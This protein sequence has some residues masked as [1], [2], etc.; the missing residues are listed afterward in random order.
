MVNRCVGCTRQFAKDFSLR[1]TPAR[2]HGVAFLTAR[3]SAR[4][5]Q[6]VSGRWL[7]S[8]RRCRFATAPEVAELRAE[9][10]G[11]QP[12]SRRDKVT[13]PGT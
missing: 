11:V 9:F 8:T 5:R 2:W 3:R 13:I 6:A 4:P 7:I 12:G 10:G 1:E